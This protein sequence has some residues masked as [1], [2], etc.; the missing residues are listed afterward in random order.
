MELIERARAV[1]KTLNFESAEIALLCVRFEDESI[2]LD[3]PF[4][5]SLN[6]EAVHD[7][8]KDQQWRVDKSDSRKSSVQQTLRSV[9]H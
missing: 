8:A 1:I 7:D 2:P 5:L 6:V 4:F 3:A 9:V